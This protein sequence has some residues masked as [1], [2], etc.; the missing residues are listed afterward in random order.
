M[1]CLYGDVAR[2]G[3]FCSVEGMGEQVFKKKEIL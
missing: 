3:A 1:Q 2:V